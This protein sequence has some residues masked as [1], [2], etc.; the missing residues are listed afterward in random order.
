[1]QPNVLILQVFFVHGNP[2]KHFRQIF[3]VSTTKIESLSTI[4]RFNKSDD[5]QRKKLNKC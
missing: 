1:M 2:R 3:K 5:K 4:K